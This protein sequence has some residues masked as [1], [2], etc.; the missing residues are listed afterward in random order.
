MTFFS[1]DE[2]PCVGPRGRQR[3]REREI[4]HKTG[5]DKK[6]RKKKQSGEFLHSGVMWPFPVTVIYE[7]QKYYNSPA[8]NQRKGSKRG[9]E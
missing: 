8:A 1:T 9:G 6:V 2:K 3:A 4:V 7:E 5:C